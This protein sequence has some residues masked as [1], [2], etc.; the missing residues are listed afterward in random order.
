MLW[1]T[2]VYLLDNHFDSDERSYGDYVACQNYPP[3]RIDLTCELF[4]S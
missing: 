2:Y 1:L 4:T 3:P